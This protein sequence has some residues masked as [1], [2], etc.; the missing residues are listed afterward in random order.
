MI[1]TILAGAALLLI[2]NDSLISEPIA[3]TLVGILF[4]TALHRY[5]IRTG[6]ARRPPTGEKIKLY[7]VFA[8]DSL[9]K[10]K[11]I[12]GKMG[13]QAG[14]AYL[15]SFWDA[16]NRFPQTAAFYRNS[17]HAYKIALVV[18]TVEDLKPLL[19]RYRN[20]CGVTMVKDAGFTVFDEPTITAIGIGPIREQDIGDDLKAIPSLKLLKKA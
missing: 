16:E 14:H 15:H 8:Q 20:V 10:M 7:A 1:E 3:V 17:D 9:D 18:P 12:A 13:A 2:I 4:I 6:R 11:G 5:I 19:K